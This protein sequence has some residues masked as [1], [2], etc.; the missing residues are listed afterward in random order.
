MLRKT[1]QRLWDRMRRNAAALAPRLQLQRVENLV[2]VGL[3]DVLAICDG[4]VAWCELKAVENYPARSTSQ[5]LGTAK[6]LSVAQ[7]NWH[8]E[9]YAH[10]GRS[11]V[12]IGVGTSEVFT[13]PGILAD[14]INTMTRAEMHRLSAAWNWAGLFEQLEPLR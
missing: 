4:S 10:G 12:V 13:I 14:G 2:G 7:R 9:W 6:G 8:Y 11:F 1:E 5:V 3:P